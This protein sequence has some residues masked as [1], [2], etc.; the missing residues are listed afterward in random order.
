MSNLNKSN[1]IIKLI[2]L[3]YFKIVLSCAL[4]KAENQ[5]V[6]QVGAIIFPSGYSESPT[7]ASAEGASVEN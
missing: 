1:C 4:P 3:N 6:V 7:P 2:T 5:I